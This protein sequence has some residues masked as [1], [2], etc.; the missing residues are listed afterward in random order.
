[1]ADPSEIGRPGHPLEVFSSHEDRETV[2]AWMA[3]KGLRRPGSFFALA[4]GSTWATKRWPV[5]RFAELARRM[6]RL[7]D[8]VIIGG[9]S[10][11]NLAAS[12]L[13]MATQGRLR[14]HSGNEA[15]QGVQVGPH[16]RSRTPAHHLIHDASGRFSPPGSVH[17]LARS[18]LLVSNDSGALHLGQAAG[19]PVLGLFGPTTADMGYVP[20]GPHDQVVGVQGLSC[21][22]CGRHGA[23]GCPLGH[24]RCMLDLDVDTVYRHLTDLFQGAA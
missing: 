19:I 18:A 7:K 11:K 24:W 12:V 4:P 20:R 16:S 8:V 15:S 10:E 22:P 17:L 9:A 21:R 14:D 23:D 1:G 2:D 3:E 6:L 5:E 13:K